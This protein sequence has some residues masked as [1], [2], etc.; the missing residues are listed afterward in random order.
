MARR[1]NLDVMQRLCFFAAVASAASLAAITFAL[2]QEP[3]LPGG[4]ASLR[5][6]HG[7]WAV[8]CAIQTQ[9]GKKAK[10]CGLSQEQFA[11]ETRQRLVAIELK[12]ASASLKGV[13]VLPFGLALDKGVTYQLDE[14]QPS[15]VQ[16]FRTCLPAGC[17]IT[18]DFDAKLVTS[19]RSAKVLRIKAAADGGQ[20]TSFSISLTGFPSA[21]D[22]TVALMK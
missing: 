13:L 9:D 3:S 19:L 8:A 15:A 1:A 11:K 4:A 21:F 16:R 14:G 10:S 18:I 2:G 5:E 22:R 17:L 20:E 7:D 6:M 12:P